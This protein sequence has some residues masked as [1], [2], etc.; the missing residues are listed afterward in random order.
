MLKDKAGVIIYLTK[1]VKNMGGNITA[2][3]IF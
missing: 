2:S 3:R 1:G